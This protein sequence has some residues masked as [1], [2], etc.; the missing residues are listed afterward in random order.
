M[1]TCI[2]M[3]SKG[4]RAAEVILRIC[5]LGTFLW[6]YI[7]FI[8]FLDNRILCLLTQHLLCSTSCALKIFVY[9][10]ALRLLSMSPSA[11]SEMRHEHSAM[12]FKVGAKAVAEQWTHAGITERRT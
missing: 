10:E 7:F 12:Q 9:T 6:H 8:I 3:L 2:Y 4:S 11:C 1:L 5:C